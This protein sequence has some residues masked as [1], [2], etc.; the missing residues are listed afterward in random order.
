MAYY[1]IKFSSADWAGPGEY[2]IV[3]ANTQYEAEVIA[4]PFMEEHMYSL[5]SDEY[6]D[7]EYEGHEGPYASVDS[8][9]ELG[10]D[11]PDWTGSVEELAE[12]YGADII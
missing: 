8:I 12:F 5:Y 4:S 6:S 11:H 2:V 9:E 10:P 3:E 1:L 7:E